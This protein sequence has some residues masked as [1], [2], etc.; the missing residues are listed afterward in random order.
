VL[1][2]NTFKQALNGPH[3]CVRNQRLEQQRLLISNDR[4]HPA[5]VQTALRILADHAA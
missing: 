3:Q 2:G 4:I 1:L 5:H